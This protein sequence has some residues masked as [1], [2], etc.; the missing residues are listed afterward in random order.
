MHSHEIC[1]D[2][3]KVSA[4]LSRSYEEIISATACTT[5]KIMAGS[6]VSKKNNSY[7]A[8]SS[9]SSKSREEHQL[10]LTDVRL[11][12]CLHR[13]LLPNSE[14]CLN[15]QHRF[16]LTKIYVFIIVALSVLLLFTWQTYL[17]LIMHN[18]VRH[19]FYHFHQIY[20]K[21]NFTQLKHVQVLFL[22]LISENKCCFRQ[23]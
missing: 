12:S 4:S 19:I 13:A 22:K 23:I 3:L 17:S 20:C 21:C 2:N 10:S 18:M 15:N 16:L 8:K 7:H 9:L 11:L 1:F 6:P 5:L 14:E